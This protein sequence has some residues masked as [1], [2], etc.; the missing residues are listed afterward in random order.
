[1]KKMKKLF[2]NV[3]S[4]YNSNRTMTIAYS[5]VL[6][7]ANGAH[8]FYKKE[9]RTRDEH[10]ETYSSFIIPLRESWFLSTEEKNNVC[11]DH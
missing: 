7:S 10:K 9:H 1:M 4:A 2:C 11:T 8:I 6:F 5:L 3:S